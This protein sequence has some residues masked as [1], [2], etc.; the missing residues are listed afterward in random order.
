MVEAAKPFVRIILRRPHAYEFK[1]KYA[2]APIPGMAILDSD[3]A[4]LGKHDLSGEDA[5]AAV[6][7]WLRKNR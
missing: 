2:D 4:F 6:R 3:G 1:K 5:V 7:D